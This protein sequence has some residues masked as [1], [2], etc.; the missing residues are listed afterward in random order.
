M[1]FTPDQFANSATSTVA[2]GSGGL[3]TPLNPSD[4][5]LH[6]PT[7]DGALFPAVAPFTLQLGTS[8]LAKCTLRSGDTL[9]LSRAQEGTTAGTW[10][11]GTTAQQ[12]LTAGNLAD[13]MTA[14]QHAAIGVYN[15]RDYGATGDGV[16]DDAAAIQ[17]ALNAANTAGGGVVYV[18]AGTYLVGTTLTL[19]SQIHLRGNGPH[20]TTIKA[21]SGL[22]NDVIQ[23]NGFLTLTGTNSGTGGINEWSVENLTID[24]NKAGNTSGY[25]LR[26]YAWNYLLEHVQI[27]SCANDGL[28]SEWGTNSNVTPTGDSLESRLYDVKSHDNLGH[29]IT[30]A[31]PH[32]SMFDTVVTYQNGTSNDGHA[33][34]Y[35]INN[36]TM[37]GGR[38]QIVNSHSWGVGQSWALKA[39]G[40]VSCSNNQWEG[41]QRA[42]VLLTG[43][44]ATHTAADSILDGDD[45]YAALPND[46]VPVGLEIGAAGVPV[47]GTV[48]RG[49]KFTNCNSGSLKFTNDGGLS[50]IDC[51][52]YQTSGSYITGSIA[53]STYVSVAGF[54]IAGGVPRT[55]LASHVLTKGSTPTLGALKAGINTQSISGNDTCGA[56][57]IQ[58][59]ASPPGAGAT[60]ASISFATAYASTPVIFT[61]S[62]GTS[63][64]GWANTSA[65]GFD[66]VPRT[67]LAA[68]TTYFIGFLVFG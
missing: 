46:T 33:G 54:G 31:G 59:T 36:T 13:I 15:V 63:S 21:K 14:F 6:L 19:Y 1:P 50:T 11:L 20:L 27:T 44:D 60:V 5:T 58:T 45:I 57:T 61:S 29:G 18:P 16:T 43:S 10:P 51:F 23:G 53:A 4:T 12:V 64:F 39:E 34:I 9:T 38:L 42:Q 35:V 66:I 3:G 49:V 24:G 8:E 26:V 41:A 28:Y 37:L 68:T 62:A 48:L 52:A 2:G 55:Q 30:W 25:G 40:S 47:S 17:A 65:S 56:L 32:D 22:N 67:A 7:G